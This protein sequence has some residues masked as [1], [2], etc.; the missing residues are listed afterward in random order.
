[1][2]RT[3]GNSDTSSNGITGVSAQF[4][5]SPATTSA[6]TYKVQT[7]QITGQVETYINRSYTDTDTTS[8]SRTISTITVMEV[9]P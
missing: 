3:S 4:L 6:T 2:R 5:D 9:T 7:Q 8:Y 1:L